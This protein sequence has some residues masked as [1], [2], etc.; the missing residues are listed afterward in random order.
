M[1]IAWSWLLLFGV[2]AVAQASD[3]SLADASYQRG[4]FAEAERLYHIALHTA[5]ST[6]R[7]TDTIAPLR[8]LASVYYQTRQFAK[9]ERLIDRV[10]TIDQSPAALA[11][12]MSN[13]A[14]V[15]EAERRYAEAECM[16]RKAVALF[17][18]S[19]KEKSAEA[20]FALNNLG[21]LRLRANDP[22]AA[23]RYLEEAVTIWEARLGPSHP[24]Y[25][26]GLS[27]LAYVY[28]VLG[29]TADSDRLWN[30]ALGIVE[31]SAGKQHVSYGILLAGYAE[32]LKKSGRKREAK[33]LQRQAK[34][35]L[36]S[37]APENPAKY[38]VDFR[39]LAAKNPIR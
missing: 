21:T 28:G 25:A 33:L 13:L 7:G 35:V 26:Q 20:A 38:T 9:A 10:L 23:A 6:G 30:R 11:Q 2:F 36:A 24:I 4:E 16:S 31:S 15:Y 32:C 1:K 12:Q 37:Q 34:S 19:G 14:A 39:D 27:N 8:G 22:Q 3:V 5:E 17:Q 18:A 29:R